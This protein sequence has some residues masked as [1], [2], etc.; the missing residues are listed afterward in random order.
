[1]SASAPPEGVAPLRCSARAVDLG[2][3]LIATADHRTGWVLLEQPGA[4]GSDAATESGLDPDLGAALKARAKA[5]GLKLLLITRADRRAVTDRRA[6]LVRADAGWIEER[7]FSDPRELLDAPLDALAAGPSPSLPSASPPP[8]PLG[9]GEPRRDPL[10]LV[11]TNGRR[12]PCCALFGRPLANAL[13]AATPDAWESSHV[14][15]HRFAA[16]LVCLPEALT[17]GRLS[18]ERGLSVVAAHREGRLDVRSLRGRAAWPVPAQA[19]EYELRLHLGLDRIDDV[20]LVSSLE[21]APRHVV[22]LL[23]RGESWRVVLEATEGEPRAT[24]CRSDKLERP[25]SWI[26]VDL[27]RG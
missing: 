4:W 5:L 17:Y 6:F 13:T 18:V 24:S 11:C 8:P 12:D 23:A 22:Q 2:E 10:Y 16:N 14:G 20:E 19:A 27:A 1:M 25:L 26:L 7:T 9:W 3:S 15:G 21:D